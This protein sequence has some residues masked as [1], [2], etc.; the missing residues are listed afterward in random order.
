MTGNANVV[1]I[2]LSNQHP[3]QLLIVAALYARVS[4]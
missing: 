3:Q 2:N 4:Q 1:T